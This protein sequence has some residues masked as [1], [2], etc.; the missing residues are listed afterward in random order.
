MWLFH[1]LFSRKRT[2]TRPRVCK[3]IFSG[4]PLLR[5]VTMN[6]RLR[7]LGQ[8]RLGQKIGNRPVPIP[9]PGPDR[10]VISLPAALGSPANSLL[11]ERRKISCNLSDYF[12][13]RNVGP[14]PFREIRAARK[15]G[16]WKT[17]ND[18]RTKSKPM[19]SI[20]SE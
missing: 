20:H 9:Y 16:L 8:D 4:S 11:P 7:E 17:G 2:Q 1:F 14:E 12:P 3:V 13:L 10:P 5:A 18:V 15:A 6:R 19:C